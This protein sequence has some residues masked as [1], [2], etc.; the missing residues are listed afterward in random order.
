[1][2]LINNITSKVSK[3]FI[4][5]ATTNDVNTNIF[6]SLKNKTFSGN[7][8]VQIGDRIILEGTTQN[9]LAGVLKR[10]TPQVSSGISSKTETVDCSLT[11]VHNCVASKIDAMNWIEYVACLATAPECYGVLW[12]ACYWDVCVAA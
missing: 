11:T 12:A 3:T 2:E 7:F 4:L 10:I 6:K 5:T 8:T 9:G 1:M